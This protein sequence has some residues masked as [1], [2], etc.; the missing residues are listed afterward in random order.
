MKIIVSAGDRVKKAQPVVVLE[1]MKMENDIVSPADGTV[2]AIHVKQGDSVNTG[3][4]LV[5]IG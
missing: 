4:L 1:A 3:D 5:S 2:L